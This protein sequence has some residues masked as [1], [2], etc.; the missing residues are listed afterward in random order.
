M[1]SLLLTN[2]NYSNT[3]KVI[4]AV[5]ICNIVFTTIQI[6][7]VLQHFSVYLWCEQ[8]APGQAYTSYR[9]KPKLLF[10]SFG[11][12]WSWYNM[13]ETRNSCQIQITWG[14]YNFH[15][16]SPLACFVFVLRNCLP[17][18]VPVTMWRPLLK[19]GADSDSESKW[20]LLTNKGLVIITSFCI[21]LIDDSTC[22][23]INLYKSS[24]KQCHDRPKTACR[25]HRFDYANKL[26]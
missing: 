4:I 5:I 20:D 21:S 25:K 15:E 23:N 3:V 18:Y 8:D 12:Q 6:F 7:V 14:F 17:F 16:E 13:F 9:L 10:D 24:D 11:C 1:Y 26:T 2:L 19:L 22:F